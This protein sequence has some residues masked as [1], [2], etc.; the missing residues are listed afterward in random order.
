MR[1]GRLEAA[2]EVEGVDLAVSDTQEVC[3]PALVTQQLAGMQQFQILNIL[4]FNVGK[5]GYE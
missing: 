1:G 3:Q 2:G 4:T 5:V